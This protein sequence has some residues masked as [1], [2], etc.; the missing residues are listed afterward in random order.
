MKT[1]WRVTIHH[2]RVVGYRADSEE[3]QTR[4][5]QFSGEM[6]VR[7]LQKVKFLRDFSLTGCQAEAYYPIRVVK[8]GRE[9]SN[10]VAKD[11]S[12]ERFS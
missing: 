2:G 3:G 11:R 12:I 6:T 5:E 9:W 7:S 4:G 1:N 10:L 8:S